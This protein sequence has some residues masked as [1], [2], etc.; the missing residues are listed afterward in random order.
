MVVLVGACDSSSR[1]RAAPPDTTA[2]HLRSDPRWLPARGPLE[3]AR[4]PPN[5]VIFPFL[6]HSMLLRPVL[7]RSP[8]PEACQ[9][10]GHRA[11]ACGSIEHEGGSDKCGKGGC[12]RSNIMQALPECVRSRVRLHLTYRYTQNTRLGELQPGTGGSLQIRRVYLHRN[13][14]S[15]ELR[16]WP[17]NS[18]SSERLTSAASTTEVENVQKA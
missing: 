9:R 13:S 5:S 4:V 14:K 17:W 6:L 7:Y 10:Q 2:E 12:I 16:K 3:P 11:G 18:L 8:H 15:I 1:E